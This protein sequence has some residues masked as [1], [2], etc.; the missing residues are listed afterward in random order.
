VGKQTVE[1]RQRIKTRIVEEPSEQTV[2]L[3]TET[4]TIER[5]PVTKETAA[6]L[7]DLQTK[8]IEVIERCEVPAVSKEGKV[9]EEVVVRKD[10][11]NR[12]ETVHGTTRRTEVET[13]I[14]PKTAS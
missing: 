6:N 14:V 13:E 12:T 4:V 10:Q 11:S 7:A 2:N 5:R 1:R 3:Q 9:V 8:D